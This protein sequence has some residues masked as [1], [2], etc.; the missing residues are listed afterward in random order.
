MEAYQKYIDTLL[1]KA[2]K[3]VSEQ[4]ASSG[5]SISDNDLPELSGG[6]MCGSADTLSSSIFHQ[7]SVSSISL[8]SPGGKSSPFA[9]DADLFFQKAPEKRKSY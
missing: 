6:V 1:E 7:L 9:A 4:L 5:F 8:H 2:C 3:I